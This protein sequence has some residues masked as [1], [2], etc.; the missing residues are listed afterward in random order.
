MKLLTHFEIKGCEADI[1]VGK[2]YI[3]LEEVELLWVLIMI[4][5]L[6]YFYYAL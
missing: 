6:L 5:I 1:N 2:S 3:G 4:L